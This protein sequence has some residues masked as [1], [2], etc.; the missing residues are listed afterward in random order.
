MKKV[1]IVI[2]FITLV[3]ILSGCQ[4]KKPKN[5]TVDDF[6]DTYLYCK[7]QERFVNAQPFNSCM[8]CRGWNEDEDGNWFK[9]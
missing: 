2:I 3:L 1:L 6:S 7:N 5:N 8:N 9:K 4:S